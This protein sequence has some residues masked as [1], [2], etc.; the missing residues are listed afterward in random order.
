MRHLAVATAASTAGVAEPR[1]SSVAAMRPKWAFELVLGAF[2]LLF[3]A[4]TGLF[5]NRMIVSP[6]DP[7]GA[8]AFMNEHHLHGN[9]LNN[10]GFGQYLIW[11]AAPAS[12]IFVDGRYDLAYPPA[13]MRDYLA[14]IRDLPGAAAVLTKYPHDYVLIAPDDPAVLVMQWA[15]GWTEIYRDQDCILYARAGSAAAAIPEAPVTGH[16]PDPE[17]FP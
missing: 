5:S 3:A 4:V 11:H 7:E 1:R 14:F 8:L 12:R 16:A 13:V 10:F 17:Y 2:A 9:I 6:P 15:R